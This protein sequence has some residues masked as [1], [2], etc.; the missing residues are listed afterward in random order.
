MK[1]IL[2]VDDSKTIHRIVSSTVELVGFEVSTA[3]NGDFALEKLKAEGDDISLILLDWNMPGM[4]GIELLRKLKEPDC[5]WKNI[6]VMMLTS[7]GSQEFITEAIK[8]GAMNYITKP[9]AQ[10]D[11]LNKIMQC[12]GQGV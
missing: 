5:K 12:L 8:T 1:K 9:F 11:L 4:T 2:C 6:P 3:L 10:E 7:E